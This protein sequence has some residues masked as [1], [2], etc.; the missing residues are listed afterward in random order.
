MELIIL[1]PA[2]P[3]NNVNYQIDFAPWLTLFL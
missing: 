1:I 2:Y 3:R